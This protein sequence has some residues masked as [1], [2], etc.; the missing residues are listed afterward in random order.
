MRFA[1]WLLWIMAL[2]LLAAGCRAPDQETVESD[3]LDV[4]VSVPPQQYFVERVGGSRVRVTVMVPPGTSPHTYEPTAAQMRGLS[5]ADL[6]LTIGESFEQVWMNRFRAANPEMR[7]VDTAAGIERVP[8]IPHDDDDEDEDDHDD[9]ELDPHIWVSPPLVAVQARTIR[10]ALVDLDP[11]ARGE[12][13]ANLDAFLADIDQLD[14]ELRA[15]LDG[16]E[17]RRFIVFHPA[18]GYFAREYGLEQIPVEVGGQEPSAAELAA[19]IRLAREDRIR[20]ILA[21]PEFSTLA[22]QTIAQE[23]NGEVVLVSPLAADWLENMRLVKD[24]FARALES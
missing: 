1:R 20:V 15:A 2:A 17:R 11:D 9:E 18:W 13:D 21:Q 14:A 8:G 19:V 6:Y 22:A 4:T 23:I 3:V 12:Y 10:D 7:V 24:A 16:M 5:R